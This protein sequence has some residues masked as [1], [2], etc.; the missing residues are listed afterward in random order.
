MGTQEITSEV[1]ANGMRV[2]PVTGNHVTGRVVM[3]RQVLDSPGESGQVLRGE[4]TSTHGMEGQGMCNPRMSSQGISQG[5]VRGTKVVMETRHGG[6]GQVSRS[7]MSGSEVFR[8]QVVG[9]EVAASRVC[10]QGVSNW[11]IVKSLAVDSKVV[12]CH[13]RLGW[14]HRGAA[15][16][17]NMLGLALKGA[18]RRHN[19]LGLALKGAARRH[20]MLGLALKGAA[21][22]HNMLGIG[23]GS[24]GSSQVP[25]HARHVSQGMGQV[26]RGMISGSRVFRSQVIGCR[27]E[28]STVCNFQVADSQITGSEL[29]GSQAPHHA[30]LGTQGSDQ[31]PQQA[32]HGTQGR[33]QAAHHAGLGTQGSDQAPQ[34][35]GH[36]TQGR[37]QAAHHA[38]L[39]T[40]GSDQAPQQAGY[41]TQGR[42][43]G[44]FLTSRKR[45]R[46]EDGHGN[47]SDGGDEDD[48]GVE[49]EHSWSQLMSNAM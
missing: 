6:G 40:Q 38:G 15:R 10:Q 18:A 34:Q 32:G 26:S 9:C 17:H 49:I 8:S 37:G 30:G 1:M 4:E 20:N 39:G 36:G 19:M 33:G 35:A 45:V 29:E 14:A 25:Q 42:E 31:A 11:P 23:L 7:R 28:E 22:R 43:R 12:M 13:N 16:R 44:A 27:V 24:L 46:C 47:G 48:E 21:R 5:D 2:D 41:G 3:G